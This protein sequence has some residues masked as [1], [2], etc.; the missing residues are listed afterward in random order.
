[1]ATD[2]PPVNFHVTGFT[3]SSAVVAW[4]VPRNRGITKYVLQRFEHDGNQFVSSGSAGRFEGAT[5]GGASHGQGNSN[6]DPD[7]LYKYV[8]MLKDDLDTTVIETSVTV[9]TLTTDG[10]ATQSNDATLSA[11]TLSGIG[12]F[13]PLPFSS[14]FTYYTATVANSMTQTTVSA[15]ANHSGASYEI[16]LG[17]AVDDD[18]VIALSVGT[19]NI[20]V[21]VTAEDGTTT[22]IYTV[23]I[24]REGLFST[25]ATLSALALS[26]I[27]FGMFDSATT[28]YTVR[29][30]GVSETTVS[31][32]TN[33]SG[34]SYEIKLNG[35]VD[36]DGVIPLAVG[37]NVISVEVTAED[38][39][40]TKTYT[41]TVT[42]AEESLLDANDDGGIDIN[43]LFTAV[44]D[45]FDNVINIA[46]LMD[47]IDLYFSST[48]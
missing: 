44:D 48:T 6:L 7:T 43:E 41:V 14:S 42:R 38:E 17:G 31:A 29:V 4:G 21:V 40:T 18:G 35:V 15:T 9:R 10:E 36:P 16:K 11:L 20:S 3:D 30:S 26:G 24:T 1:M 32:T 46:Q 5:N 39:S 13:E 27:D 33:H 22:K 12:E 45:Y 47:V 37:S 34:A 8:L 19:N 23:I 28:Q 25:D 2:D